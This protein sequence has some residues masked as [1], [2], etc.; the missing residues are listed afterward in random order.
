MSGIAFEQRMSDTE[1]LMWRLDR[2]PRL[3]STFANVSILDRP[4]DFDRF[5]RRM[6]RAA[7]VIPRLCQIVREPIGG[8]GTPRWVDDPDFDV[9]A[10]VRRIALPAPGSDR[11]L[12]DLASLVAADPFDRTRPLWQFLVV[13]GLDRGRAALIQKV[14]HTIS[15]GEGGVRLSLEF[16]DLDRDPPIPPTPIEPD[17]PAGPAAAEDDFEED[18]AAIAVRE[19][20]AGALRL[21]LGVAGRVRELLAEPARID[22]ANRA[23]AR[24]WQG[25]VGSVSGAERSRSPLWTRRSAR[26]HLDVV[27][28][29]LGATKAAASR[30]GG[31]LNTAFLTIV[32]E[33]CGA[34]HAELGAPTETLRASMALST[35]RAGSGTNSFSLVRLDVP[36]GDMPSD[37]RFRAIERATRAA[38]EE[39]ADAPLETMTALAATLPTPIVARLA[40]EQVR[41]VDFAT[42]NVKGSPVP[43]FVAG[44]R[45]LRHVPV[46]PLTG[47]AFNLTLLS[48]GDNLDMGLHTDRAAVERPEVLAHHL[49]AAVERFVAN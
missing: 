26:R 12:L 49:E 42:S 39:Q 11:Q 18:A 10:H 21:P 14:H 2:D 25:I 29:P 1:G 40:R 35:R 15:D 46:G 5:R 13:E 48:Y 32:A 19:A 36:T 24:T 34:Y 30:L 31:T 27:T 17:A 4:P 41:T 20:L 45:V 9:D 47:V 38:V 8:L 16:H 6:E 33:A 7:Q 43:L 3:S 22:E 37:E 23:A 44:A 28:A